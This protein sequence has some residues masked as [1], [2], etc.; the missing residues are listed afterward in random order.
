MAQAARL[1]LKHARLQGRV[2]TDKPD[3]RIITQGRY[4]AR[5]AQE[6]GAVR[7]LLA[8]I[9]PGS[10][11][12]LSSE[13][14]HSVFAPGDDAAAAAPERA[15]GALGLRASVEKSNGLIQIVDRAV[16]PATIRQG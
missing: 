13:A 1:T 3:A 16:P 5:P 4:I 9:D 6:A 15:H 11:A 10:R 14:P 7:T 8:A 2:L 12:E